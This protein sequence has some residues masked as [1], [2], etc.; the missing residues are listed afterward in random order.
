MPADQHLYVEDTAD[1]EHFI[2]GDNVIALNAE[3]EEMGREVIKCVGR[4]P[5]PQF[6]CLCFG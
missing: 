2:A 6:R 1:S 3:R 5:P 4:V